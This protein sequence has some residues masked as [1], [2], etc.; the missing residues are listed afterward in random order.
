MVPLAR[1]SA[2]LVCANRCNFLEVISSTHKGSAKNYD[3]LLR[4]R[5]HFVDEVQLIVNHC[6]LGVP[7]VRKEELKRVLSHPQDDLDNITRF[8]ILPREPIIVF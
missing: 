3:L 1:K 4:H 5:L 6:L 7:G 2:K 8:L